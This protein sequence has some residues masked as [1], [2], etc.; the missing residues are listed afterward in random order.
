MKYI[1]P[2]KFLCNNTCI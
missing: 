1:D 2:V